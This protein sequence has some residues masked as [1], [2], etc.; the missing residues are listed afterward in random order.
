MLQKGKFKHKTQLQFDDMNTRGSCSLKLHR[1]TD[2]TVTVCVIQGVPFLLVC[3]TRTH[4]R[5]HTLA[6]TRTHSKELT[7][8]GLLSRCVLI[9]AAGLWV[10]TRPEYTHVNF[11]LLRKCVCC[12][13]IHQRWK[14][15][16]IICYQ[17]MKGAKEAGK[18]RRKKRQYRTKQSTKEKN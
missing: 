2:D 18:E 14:T 1:A 3:H 8:A 15:D 12:G 5:T 10:N 11:H 16:L 4:T 9:L 7:A 13:E 17:S 6:H